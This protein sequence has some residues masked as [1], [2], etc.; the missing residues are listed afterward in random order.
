MYVLV[1][2]IAQI[3]THSAYTQV[4]VHLYLQ[5]IAVHLVKKQTPEIEGINTN[6]KQ[7]CYVTVHLHNTLKVLALVEILL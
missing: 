7:T 4:K 6:K 3:M 1:A 5:Q 2:T